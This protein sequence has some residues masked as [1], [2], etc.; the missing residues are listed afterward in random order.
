MAH[1][2]VHTVYNSGRQMWE[3]KVEANPVPLSSH[4]TKETAQ[5]EGRGIAKAAQVEHLIHG[6]NG[7]IQAR[8]SYG[9][10]PFPPRG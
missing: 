1:R 7:R 6:R 9:R 8:N 4:H 2:N 10:D 5:A 3:N